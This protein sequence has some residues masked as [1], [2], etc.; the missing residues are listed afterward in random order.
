MKALLLAAGVGTRMQPLTNALPKC[1][2]PILGVPLLE[3]W[4]RL[5]ESMGVREVIVNTNY[6]ALYAEKFLSLQRRSYV[7]EITHEER[8]LGTAGT[9]FKHIHK[10]R[11]SDTIVIH[12]DNLSLFQ[13]DRFLD[14]FHQRPKESVATMMTFDTDSPK[15]CGVVE[16]NNSG[17]VQTMYEKVDD[18]PSTLANAAV[19]I[20]SRELLQELSGLTPF[21]DLSLELIPKLF[22]RMNT[23]HNSIYHRDIGS[24]QAY[25][26][27]VQDAVNQP[28]LR[29]QVSESWGQLQSVGL[30][31]EWVAAWR[32]TAYEILPFNSLEESRHSLAKAKE[33]QVLLLE[34]FRFDQIEELRV[35][36]K[37][38]PQLQVI[39]WR[40]ENA[41]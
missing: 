36:Q 18:P 3:I 23:F 9:L 4:L 13:A 27:S 7:I 30:W 40:A 22:G 39:P 12:A 35:A 33:N 17:L 32:Q 41:T 29:L 34:R 19:Y 24:I 15:T 28:N 11:D 6:K 2:M 10:L 37:Q 16:L 26:H 38:N 8:L 25:I 5:L 21:S 1:L 31:N 14:T 20:F